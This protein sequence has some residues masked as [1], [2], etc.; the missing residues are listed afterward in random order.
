[1]ANRVTISPE[2]AAVVA[3]AREAAAEAGELQSAP[4]HAPAPVLSADVRA[5]V[6]DWRSSGDYDRAVAEI[7]A[8]D[9]D[10]A[11]E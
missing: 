7:V 10:L 1:M 4:T 2:L 3:A 9:P 8:G 11:T 6:A 5:V